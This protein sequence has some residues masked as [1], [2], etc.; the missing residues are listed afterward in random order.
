M[1]VEERREALR[2][3]EFVYDEFSDACDAIQEYATFIR[4]KYGESSRSPYCLN[5]AVQ[6]DEWSKFFK[7]QLR[8]ITAEE[9][10]YNAGLNLH[11]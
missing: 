11:L 10:A 8:R 4:N 5:R 6:R 3:Y 9:K 2:T 7:L 1:T